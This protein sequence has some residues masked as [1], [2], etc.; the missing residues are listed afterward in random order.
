LDQEQRHNSQ[1]LKG[2]CASNKQIVGDV[3]LTED[4]RDHGAKSE[5]AQVS[6]LHIC[7]FP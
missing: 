7:S 2:G 5:I 6:R 4:N 3:F 1:M